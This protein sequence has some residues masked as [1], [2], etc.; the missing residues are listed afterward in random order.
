MQ[1]I[2]QTLP[3]LPGKPAQF[4]GED[5]LDLGPSSRVSPLPVEGQ[6]IGERLV[7]AR[8]PPGG[9]HLLQHPSTLG[10]ERLDPRRQRLI[11]V[12]PGDQ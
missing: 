9:G 7:D 2:Y 6:L 12:N 1:G 11:L 10:D 3:L 5:L 8:R 4:R